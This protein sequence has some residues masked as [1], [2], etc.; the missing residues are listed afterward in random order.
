M[1]TTRK[2]IVNK[3]LAKIPAYLNPVDF[4]YETLNVSKESVYRRLKGEVAFS[5]EDMVKMSSRLFISLDEIVYANQENEL[6]RQPIIFRSD[7]DKLFDPQKSFLNFLQAYDQSMEMVAKSQDVEIIAAANHLMILSAVSYDHLFKFYY[8]RW[9][10]Q[11]QYKPLDFSMSD[12]ILSDELLFL[13]QKLKNHVHSGS[14]THI[15]DHYFL[16]NIIREIQYYYNRELITEAEMLII[17]EELYEFIDAT[18]SILRNN[19]GSKS[20]IDLTYISSMQINS[21][22]L[23]CRCDDKEYVSLWISFGLFIRSENARICETYRNWLNSLKK[24]SSLMSGCNE[25]LR[26]QFINCQRKYIKNLM[27]KKDLYG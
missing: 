17:Q 6:G 5:L 2:R 10:H 11:T 18:D 23:Y 12:V 26:T 27:N 16:R 1:D 3:I 4:L 19:T 25:I 24:Y 13:Q 7:S 15:L 22:G 9:M 20:Y 14:H 21:S 8:F